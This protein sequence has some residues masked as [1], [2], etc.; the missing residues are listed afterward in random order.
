MISVQRVSGS[1]VVFLRVS[2]S[3]LDPGDVRR[4]TRGRRD[5]SLGK[6]ETSHA[7]EPRDRRPQLLPIVE[8][9]RTCTSL[10]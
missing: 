10:R 2:T 7:E 9:E 5:S 3:T 6:F 1:R 8:L 4:G